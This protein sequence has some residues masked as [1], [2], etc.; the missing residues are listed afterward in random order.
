MSG[1]QPSIR[2][3]VV[4]RS[5]C[6][7]HACRHRLR[8]CQQ[9]TANACVPGQHKKRQETM[10]DNDSVKDEMATEAEAPKAEEGMDEDKP[11]EGSDLIGSAAMR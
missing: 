1:D 8:D 10:S 9:P 4:R 6:D 7:L 2:P 3:P 11:K 5:W